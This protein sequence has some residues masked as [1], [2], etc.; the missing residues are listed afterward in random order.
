[1][2]NLIKIVSEVKRE[3]QWGQNIMGEI[4]GDEM[5]RKKINTTQGSM[6]HE[7]TSKLAGVIEGKEEVMI[8]PK[9]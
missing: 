6:H 8:S 4:G 9:G 3:D 7:K 1:M 2:G 5:S